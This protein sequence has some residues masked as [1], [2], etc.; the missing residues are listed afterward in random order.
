[1]ALF[2]QKIKSVPDRLWDIT[3][4]PRKTKPT[5]PEQFHA[6]AAD[7]HSPILSKP[8]SQLCTRNQY[9]EPEYKYWVDQIKEVPR[10]HRKQWEFVYILRVLHVCGMLDEGRR[11]LGFGVGKEPLPAVMAKHGVQVLAT[12]LDNNDAK[13]RLWAQAGQHARGLDSLNSYNICDDKTFARLVRFEPADM[14]NI[15]PA[16]KDFDFC[17]SACA[18]EHLGSIKAGLEFVR[19][20]LKCLRPGGVAIHTTEYNCYSDSQTVR[21]GATVLFRMQDFLKLGAELRAQGHEIQFN[22]CQGSDPVDLHVDVPPYSLDTHLKL[23]LR[24]YVTTSIGVLVT[25]A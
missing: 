12:D 19:N 24:K 22:F 5:I 16:Y 11:G 10:L 6:F 4:P 7:V 8:I 20:S 2:V 17:W 1:M 15:S 3:I 9:E 13:S 25:V 23:Q 18:F 14:N 21:Y